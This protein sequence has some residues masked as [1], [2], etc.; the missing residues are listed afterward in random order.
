MVAMI[1]FLPSVML[2]GI[3]FPA[4]MLPDFMQYLAYIF[5]ATIGFQAMTDL[6]IWHLPVL[7]ILFAAFCAVI[8]LIL[9]KSK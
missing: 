2:S 9:T 4:T 7:A 1:I 6:A 3:M 8:A 5:P